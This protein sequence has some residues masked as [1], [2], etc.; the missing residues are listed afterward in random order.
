MLL[1]RVKERW[2]IAGA[3]VTPQVWKEGRKERKH[4]TKNVNERYERNGTVPTRL[5]SLEY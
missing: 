2:Y 3:S 4:I 5:A 1:N